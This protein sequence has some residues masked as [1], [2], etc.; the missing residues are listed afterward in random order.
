MYR[1]R[2]IENLLGQHEELEKQQIYFASLDQLND[3]MEGTRRYFWKGDKIVWENLMKHYLL[4]LER[5]T[6][7]STLLNDDEEILR[8]HI[9]I[10]ECLSK[11]PTEIYKERMKKIYDQFFS[12]KFVQAHIEFVTRN[13]NNVYQEELYVHLRILSLIALDSILTVNKENGFPPSISFENVKTILNQFDFGNAWTSTNEDEYKQFIWTIHET[14]KVWDTGLLHK[15]RDLPKIQFLLI[16]FT[17]MYLDVIVELTYPKSYVACFMDNCTNPSIWGT[18]GVNHTGVCLKF[19][20]NNENP[21]LELKAITSY[22]SS[23][24]GYN[25]RNFEM[26]PI[27]YSTSFDELDFFGNIGS[28][29]MP[30]LKEQWYTDDNGVYSVCSDNVL[31]KT[32]EWRK[33]HWSIYLGAYLKKLPEW[34]HEREYRIILT[35]ALN[36]Y[37]EPENRLLEYKFEDLESIIFGMKTPKKARLEII[38]IIKRK[39]KETGR[40]NFDIYEMAY[41]IEINEFY[42]RKM[43]SLT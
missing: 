41:S 15:F 14:L 38:D 20:T 39:C 36:F 7:L 25:Y 8:E 12:S 40:T 42:P 21:T 24:Y 9:P 43:M 35:S 23:G 5:I 34:S 13:Q 28:L 2:S 10:Y 37:D 4:C 6:M 3:P 26:H 19:K 1:F 29:P 31:N 18:Y 33:Q 22:G 17:Q 11:L 32:D 27:E 16:E 30:Q